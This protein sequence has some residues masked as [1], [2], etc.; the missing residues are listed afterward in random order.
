MRQQSNDHGPNPYCIREFAWPSG[1]ANPNS[2]W[3]RTNHFVCSRMFSS[4]SAS[5]EYTRRRGEQAKC[6]SVQ[7]KPIPLEFHQ[8]CVGGVSDSSFQNVVLLFHTLT[9]T[10]RAGH[11]L[12]PMYC[13][14]LEWAWSV[15]V[16]ARIVVFAVVSSFCSRKIFYYFF[17]SIYYCDFWNETR[18]DLCTT[19]Y[20][21]QDNIKPVRLWGPAN[22]TN[23][24]LLCGWPT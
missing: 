21:D 3:P 20:I 11:T 12:G 13:D 17:Y 24:Y 5:R 9:H 22:S 18:L 2:C 10:P 15:C 19:V 8:T 14:E 23:V 16:F 7:Y 6:K 4:T 1:R